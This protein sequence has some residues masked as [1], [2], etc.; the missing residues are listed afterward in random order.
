VLI[1]LFFPKGV[2]GWLAERWPRRF[3]RGAVR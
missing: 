2:M 1:V 3:A